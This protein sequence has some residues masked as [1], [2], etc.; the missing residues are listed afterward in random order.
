MYIKQ[1]LKMLRDLE[2]L[3]RQTDTFDTIFSLVDANSRLSRKRLRKCVIYISLHSY[4]LHF[5]GMTCTLKVA[6]D[7]SVSWDTLYN[8]QNLI[9]SLLACLLFQ[10]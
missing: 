5:G 8:G 10:Q 7:S 2:G 3:Y 1:E 4:L 6:Q 9:R